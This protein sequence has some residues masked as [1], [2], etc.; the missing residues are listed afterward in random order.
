M[1]SRDVDA[2]APLGSIPPTRL[3]K[4]LAKI[5]A[6]WA[7][8]MAG[9]ASRW[10]TYCVLAVGATLALWG[11]LL[12]IQPTDEPLDGFIARWN[13]AVEAEGDAA[14]DALLD[15]DLIHANAGAWKS[16]SEF[17]EGMRT[18]GLAVEPLEADAPAGA[19][20]IAARATHTP[21]SHEAQLTLDWDEREVALHL[22]RGGWRKRWSVT[23]IVTTGP[24]VEAPQPLPIEPAHDMQVSANVPQ[25]SKPAGEV[26]LVSLDETPPLDTE[27]KLRQILESWR[28]AWE[29]KDIDAY[30]EWY[31][32]YATV[33]RVTVVN[34]HEIPETLTKGQLKARMKRL[35]KRYS[36]IKVDVSNVR[37]RGSYAEADMRFQQ[38]FAAWRKGGDGGPTYQDKGIKTLKFVNDDGD[39]R[40]Y[41]ESWKTYVDVPSYPLN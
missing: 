33:L 11:G 12:M 22:Q 38:D 20:T 25:V 29:E 37:I 15:Q 9:R 16:G 5:R 18:D 31:A 28:S 32:D 2:Q 17:L 3:E 35:V 10:G 1:D 14:Y 4:L 21:G 26:S 36:R 23:D 30:M 24:V 39:W 34:S 7:R 6:G 41:E 13:A 40:I 27:F 8:L 19:V